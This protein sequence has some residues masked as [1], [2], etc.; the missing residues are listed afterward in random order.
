ME[1]LLSGRQGINLL[2]LLTVICSEGGFIF[3][4]S[5]TRQA[6]WNIK[7]LLLLEWEL[8]RH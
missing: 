6:V 4:L 5:D 3:N 2:R 1:C 7:G 8:S